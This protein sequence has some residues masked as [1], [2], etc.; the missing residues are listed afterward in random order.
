MKN[1]L[2]EIKSRKLWQTLLVYCGGGFG[3]M[4]VVQRETDDN[5]RVWGY[6]MMYTVQKRDSTADAALREYIAKY[7]NEAAYEVGQIY[8][9]RGESNLAF[10]W[11]ERAYR[12]RDGGLLFMKCDPFLKNIRNDPRYVS[13]LKKMNLPV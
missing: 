3:L 10:Q 4:Q 11:L 8:A 5:F 9:Y 13:F 2:D 12:Q 1:L 7:Q 6:A